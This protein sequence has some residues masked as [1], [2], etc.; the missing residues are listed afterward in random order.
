[1]DVNALRTWGMTVSA[2]AMAGALAIALMG[3]PRVAPDLLPTDSEAREAMG[4]LSFVVQFNGNGPVAR[5][6]RAH[7]DRAI[8]LQLRRQYDL[9]GLCFD[10]FGYG[11]EVVLSACNFVAPSERESTGQLWL[12]RLRAMRAVSYVDID[13]NPPP[14][15]RV[16]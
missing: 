3:E 13:R 15:S 2:A 10:R 4:V 7:D 5:A 16:D 9:N 1:M 14:P 8:G 12:A 11:A 6:A